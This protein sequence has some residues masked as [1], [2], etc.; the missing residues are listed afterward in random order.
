M[1][2]FRFDFTI[3]I[4]PT[5]VKAYDYLAAHPDINVVL[6]DQRMPV[7]T[8]VEFFEE[9]KVLYPKPVRMLIT[10][11]SDIEAVIDS[12]NRGSVF[13]YIKKPWNDDDV[14]SAVLEANKFYISNSLL[15]E[16]NKELAAAYRELGKFAYSVTHDLRSPLSSLLGA[17][18]VSRE[19]D[20]ITDVREILEM[21]DVAV[22]K[23]D[24]F[25]KNIH[26]FYS[27]KR[28]LASVE[29]IDFNAL[30][31]DMA[32]MFALSVRMDG[33]KFV[34][35]VRQD[36]PFFSDSASL[37]I[38]VI[39]LLSNA[40]KYQKKGESG[41]F[42]E[43]DIEVKA[44]AATITV[45]DNG[46]GIPEEHIKNIFSMFYRAT[47]EQSGSGFGLFNVKDALERLN[48]KVEVSSQPDQ[49][50]VFRVSIPAITQ[51]PI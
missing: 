8:G 26:E 6:A 22:R 36:G 47:T 12:V 20:S 34:H 21:M 49:G 2:T 40:F 37:R 18:E 17:L 27:L 14:K 30:A 51:K 13:R 25:I 32:A 5:A 35:R 24:D 33:I 3:Y 39:N 19:M 46:I 38:I 50:S 16:K 48:G 31:D 1:A 7:Q 28:G 43:L 41:K 15:E 9:M 42:V 44:D 11:Y 23:L 45:R 29:D 10:A 4:A